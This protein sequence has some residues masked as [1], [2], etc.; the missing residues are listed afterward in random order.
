MIGELIKLIG[1]LVQSISKATIDMIK[2][3]IHSSA[4]LTN[5]SRTG[6]T[7]VV[8]SH[9]RYQHYSQHYQQVTHSECVYCT[10]VKSTTQRFTIL[11]I[12]CVQSPNMTTT[13]H[14]IYSDTMYVLP[15]VLS[16]SSFSQYNVHIIL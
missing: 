14:S 8:L 2:Q 4:H 11:I 12:V 6:Q 7:V 15:S 13:P 16:V 5:R 1:E 3:L 10:I 9:Y